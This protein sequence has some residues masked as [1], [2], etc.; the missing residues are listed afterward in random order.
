MPAEVGIDT[1]AA[2][3]EP[4]K[5][6]AYRRIAA[7]HW[8]TK[9]SREFH[10]NSGFQQTLKQGISVKFSISGKASDPKFR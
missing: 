5:T 8:P 4:I 10:Q 7:S 9:C 3:A 6:D 1:A 2:R